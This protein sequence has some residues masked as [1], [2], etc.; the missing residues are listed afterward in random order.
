MRIR[1]LLLCLLCALNA[2]AQ[3]PQSANREISILLII[4]RNKLLIEIRNPYA[5][6][7]TMQNGMPVAQDQRQ[8]YGCRS[9]LSVVQQRNGI[10][11]FEAEEGVF[12]LQI[13]IPLT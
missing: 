4:S 2:A 11:S 13:A 10:C 8:H 9:I 1:T 3:L 12:L 6:S 7:I 5:G